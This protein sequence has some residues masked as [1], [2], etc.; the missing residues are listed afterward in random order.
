[1]ELSSECKALPLL[2]LFKELSPTEL[3]HKLYEHLKHQIIEQYGIAKVTTVP[4]NSTED[5]KEVT[6]KECVRTLLIG[7]LPAQG[8]QVMFS[9]E[10]QFCLAEGVMGPHGLLDL[11]VGKNTTRLQ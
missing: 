2:T 1:M 11:M 9:E 5:H 8:E 4:Q 10:V 7:L 3:A 6:D